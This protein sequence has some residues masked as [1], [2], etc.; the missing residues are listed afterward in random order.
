MQNSIRTIS[1][2]SI[3]LLSTGVAFAKSTS[4][5]TDAVKAAALKAYPDASIKSCKA[6]K[7]DKTIIDVKITTKDKKKLEVHVAAD[8]TINR[9]EET[10]D[11]K[12]V[13]DVVTKAF[14]AKYTAKVKP[15]HAHKV[16]LPDGKTQYE[17]Q[18]APS[19]GKKKTATFAD[20]GTF[21]SEE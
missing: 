18:F 2:L 5:C 21:V 12:T 10:V 16:T 3:L 15:N 8:G 7:A 17:L 9:T 14:T 13:P 19:K 11:V 4:A 20:D 1:V 6:E